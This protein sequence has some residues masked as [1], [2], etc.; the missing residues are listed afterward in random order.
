MRHERIDGNFI[1]YKN[2]EIAY[3][4]VGLEAFETEPFAY[5]H[6][7]RAYP[8]KVIED[9]YFDVDS[10]LLHG[11]W[12]TSSPRKDSPMFYYDYREVGGVLFPHIWMR[13]HDKTAPPHLFIVE[14]VKIN[15]D[16]GKDFF[17]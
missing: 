12:P 5:Y 15:E 14:E 1:D 8:D 2:Q 16:F 9:L 10:G 3:E 13:V 6:L 4:Y 17:K 7:R 11:I